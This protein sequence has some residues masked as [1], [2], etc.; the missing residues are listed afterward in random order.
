MKEKEKSMEEAFEELNELLTKM[1]SDQISLEDS[2]K[3]YQEG[4]QLVRYCN[5]KIDKVEKQ[6]M[7]LNEMGEEN[8]G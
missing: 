1:D 4:V 8:G 3:L 7:I 6:L 2:F 5:E